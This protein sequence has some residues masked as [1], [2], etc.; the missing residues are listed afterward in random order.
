MEIKDK[1][2]NRLLFYTGKSVNI[3]QHAPKSLLLL[4]YHIFRYD[5]E[6]GNIEI[7]SEKQGVEIV[8]T[9][10]PVCHDDRTTYLFDMRSIYAYDSSSNQLESLYSVEKILL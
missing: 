1:E 9:L 7:A 5:I 10:T 6:T 4:G 3:Y 8:G 2:I